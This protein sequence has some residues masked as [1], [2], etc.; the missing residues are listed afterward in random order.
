MVIRYSCSFF[1]IRM[2]EEARRREFP[3]TREGMLGFMSIIRFN[4]NKTNGREAQSWGQD[5]AVGKV[6]AIKRRITGFKNRSWLQKSKLASENDA[7]A[8]KGRWP[9]EYTLTLA[10]LF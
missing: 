4:S 9:G 8:I 6:L 10:Q 1:L 7:W 3:H 2:G 5:Y